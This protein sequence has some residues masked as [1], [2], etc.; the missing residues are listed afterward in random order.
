MDYDG[1]FHTMN[2]ELNLQNKEYFR[3][4]SVLYSD[5]KSGAVIVNNDSHEIK[6]YIKEGRLLITE[7]PDSEI[8]LLKAVA[9]KKGL[10]QSEFNEL[11]KIKEDAPASLGELLIERSLVSPHF[12]NKFLFFKAKYHLE[13]M[14]RMANAHFTFEEMLPDI[15]PNNELNYNLKELLIETIRDIK[16]T[17][18]IKKL[19]PESVTRFERKKIQE[20]NDTYNFLNDTEREVFSAIDGKKTVEEIALHANLNYPHV[21]NVLSLFLLLDLISSSQGKINPQE[22]ITYEEII[23][24]YLDIFKILESNFNKEIGEEFAS[25]LSQ[26]VKYLTD[27]NISLFQDIDLRG[28]PSREISYEINNRFL[29]LLKN[30]ASHLALFTSFNKLI[31]LLLIRM[32]EILGVSITEKTIN[33]MVDMVNYIKKYRPDEYIMGYIEDNLQDYLTQV[34]S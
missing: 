29:R 21:S 1:N 27:Q 23:G 2:L 3:F 22:N 14:F 25:V 15:P 9:A 11:V 6:I 16:D 30:G 7:G 19:I 34:K 13:L 24:V 31:Y 12:W 5:K 10:G 20:D 33:E 8:A 4:F 18:F 28:V 26:C 32:K 17:I